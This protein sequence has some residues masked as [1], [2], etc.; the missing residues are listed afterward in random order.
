MSRFVR[1][2]QTPSQSAVPCRILSS[3]EGAFPSLHTLSSVWRGWRSGLQP[4]K[5]SRWY[6]PVVLICISLMMWCWVIF[7]RLI[8]HQYRFSDG[9][10]RSSFYFW[11]GCVFFSSLS[12]KISLDMLDKPLISCVFFSCGLSSLPLD[13]VFP[14][15]PV[16]NS[17]KFSLSRIS[18]TNHVFGAIW[19]NASP[20]SRSSRSSPMLSSRSFAVLHSTLRSTIDF[21]FGEGIRCASRSLF[22]S[23]LLGSS[24]CRCRL[25]QRRWHCLCFTASPLLLCQRPVECIYAVLFQTFAFFSTICPVSHQDTLPWLAYLS[26]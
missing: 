3:N 1:K 5:Q 15:E 26:D 11:S 4:F 22:G 19:K 16:F 18:F 23:G 14:R 12:F 2:R 21:N 6:L 7:S 20:Y 9:M 13:I 10:S 17:V 8:C 25:F 24:A